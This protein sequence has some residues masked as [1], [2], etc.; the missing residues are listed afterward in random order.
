MGLACR[1]PFFGVDLTLLSPNFSSLHAHASAPSSTVRFD[2]AGGKLFGSPRETVQENVPVLYRG[3][4]FHDFGWDG[5]GQEVNRETVGMRSGNKS[6]GR[7]IDSWLS[8]QLFQRCLYL[9]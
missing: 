3:I 4:G 2:A 5:A 7:E 6:G 9:L 1:E 8:W